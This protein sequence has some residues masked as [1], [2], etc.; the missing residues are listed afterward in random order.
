ML[1]ANIIKH[2]KIASSRENHGTSDDNDK[3][4]DKMTFEFHRLYYF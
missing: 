1:N 4:V 2:Y 3:V